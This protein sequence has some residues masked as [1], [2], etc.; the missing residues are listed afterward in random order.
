[1]KASITTRLFRPL[2]AKV[3]TCAPQAASIAAEAELSAFYH[4][5]RA[6]YG[7]EHAAVATEHWL[8][9]LATA[10]IDRNDLKSSFRK[11]TVQAA[12]LLAADVAQ[13]KQRSKDRLPCRSCSRP[14]VSEC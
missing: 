2:M 14:S 10:P 13:Q 6:D 8:R 7:T 11:I 3:C 9:V 12:T 1:M 4:A 5:V